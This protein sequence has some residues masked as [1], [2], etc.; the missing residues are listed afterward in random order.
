MLSRRN[1]LK[2]ALGLA[3]VLTH[4]GRV[5]PADQAGSQ[6]GVSLLPAMPSEDVFSYLRRTAG[7][8]NSARYKQ[9]LGAANPFKEGDQIVGVAAADDAARQSARALVAATRLDQI[10]AHP[11][12]EDNLFRLLQQSIDQ[13]AA[14]K[15][16]TLTLG[17]LTRLLLRESENEIR[18]I[19]PGLSSDVI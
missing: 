3:G 11:P 15:T 16:A 12:L 13:V 10:N 2:R 1:L 19:M 4:P 18:R 8:V 5:F 6:K 17:E 14:A 9:I 7:G